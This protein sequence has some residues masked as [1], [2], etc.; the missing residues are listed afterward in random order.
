[1][2]LAFIGS[3]ELDQFPLAWVDLYR[4]AARKAA[5]HGHT[6]VTGAA[7]GADQLAAETALAAGGKVELVLPWGEFNREW[8]DSMTANYSPARV[9]VVT[10]VPLE[11][12]DWTQSVYDYHPACQNGKMGLRTGEFRLHARNYGIVY[13]S[14]TVVALPGRKRGGG[15][16]GQ[17]LR[18]AQGLR[19]RLFDLSQQQGRDAL[20][21]MLAPPIRSAA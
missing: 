15:G 11:C 17:G 12:P 1:V 8:V 18:V 3:R 7:E 14:K 6:V 9:T 10:Y 21:S 20:T 13:N 4:E 5:I 19:I 2:R 16:T